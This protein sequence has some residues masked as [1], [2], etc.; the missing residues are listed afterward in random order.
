MLRC[1]YEDIEYSGRHSQEDARLYIYRF[2]AVPGDKLGTPY[3]KE[4]AIPFWV[5]LTITRQLMS[6]GTWPEAS[7]VER[8]K[9]FLQYAKEKISE[10][11]EAPK[12]GD[13]IEL[14]LSTYTGKGPGDKHGRFEHGPVYTPENI[15]P[16]EP[17]TVG[18]PPRTIPGFKA[19]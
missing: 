18:Q 17:F 12:D 3:E 2:R 10:R 6:C 1:S 15:D 9:Q 14:V 7:E 16:A 13:I 5:E 8:R 11:E 4:A 19:D